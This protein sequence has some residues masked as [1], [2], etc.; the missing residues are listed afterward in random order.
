MLV[1]L[2]HL[3]A[4]QT[5]LVDG[6]LNLSDYRQYI[7]ACEYADFQLT[8]VACCLLMQ[9][10]YIY[11]QFMPQVLRSERLFIT[12]LYKNHIQMSHL[13]AQDHLMW[14]NQY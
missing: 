6:S 2:H 7:E 10:R 9:C 14:A 5:D 11:E 3:E 13:V 12:A 4:V 1:A 8:P